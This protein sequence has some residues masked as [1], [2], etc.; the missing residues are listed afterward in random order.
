[1]LKIN[2]RKGE[3]LRIVARGGE[4]IWIQVLRSG[5]ITGIGIEAPDDVHVMREEL[6]V[7]GRPGTQKHMDRL[8][9]RKAS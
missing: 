1:M 3:R 8:A 5:E 2:R 7:P 9:A 4:E 6:I